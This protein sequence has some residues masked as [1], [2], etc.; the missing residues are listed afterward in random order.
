[1]LLNNIKAFGRAVAKRYG[2]RTG[3]TYGALLAGAYFLGS[4]DELDEAGAMEWMEAQKWELDQDRLEASKATSE[5][6][7]CLARL[8]RHVVSIKDQDEIGQFLT[9]DGHNNVSLQEVILAV[10]KIKTEPVFF[11]ARGPL[12]AMETALGRL[13]IKVDEEEGLVLTTSIRGLVEP[14]YEGTKWS[15]GAFK[16][17]LLDLNGARKLPAHKQMRFKGGTNHKSLIALPMALIGGE[18]PA[19]AE[20]PAEGEEGDAVPA[21]AERPAAAAP[22]AMAPEAAPAE[23]SVEL[24]LSVEMPPFDFG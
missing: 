19:A 24:A 21:A 15:G 23:R 7:R 3:D 11:E 8:L 4:L 12:G 16:E 1:M 9:L 13:G 20:R 10:W 2:G 17:R 14:I 5:S 22:T 6:E 18:A